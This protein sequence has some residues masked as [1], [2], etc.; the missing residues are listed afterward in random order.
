MKLEDALRFRD[1]TIIGVIVHSFPEDEQERVRGIVRD[2][3][4]RA[5]EVWVHEILPAIVTD[6]G[7]NEYERRLREETVGPNPA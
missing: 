2:S 5:S 6:A 3:F 1:E 4:Q 7:K